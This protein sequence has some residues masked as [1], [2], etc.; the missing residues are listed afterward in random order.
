MF[1]YMLWRQSCRP[2]VSFFP[3]LSKGGGGDLFFLETKLAPLLASSLPQL[4]CLFAVPFHLFLLACT[5]GV[6]TLR[7]ITDIFLGGD[8]HRQHLLEQAGVFFFNKR[9]VVDIDCC[10]SF[11]Q[12]VV[13]FLIS[14][15]LGFAPFVFVGETR[16][17]P[18]VKILL[19]P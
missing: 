9:G 14:L 19:W 4:F 7:Y 5:P 2:L 1:Q 17:A 6:V 10:H 18:A 11:S 15:Y 16:P 8:P 13:F 12:L 3:S